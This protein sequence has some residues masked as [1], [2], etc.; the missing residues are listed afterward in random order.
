MPKISI[1]LK[2]FDCFLPARTLLL[3]IIFGLPTCTWYWKR[4]FSNF[5]DGLEEAQRLFVQDIAMSQTEKL[6]KQNKHAVS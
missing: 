2:R 4:T 1:I 3:Q 6:N 5:L